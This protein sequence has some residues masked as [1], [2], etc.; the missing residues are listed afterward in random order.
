MKILILSCD[1]GQGHN[2]AARAVEEAA[3]RRSIPC[4]LANPLSFG[5]KNRAGS[6]QTSTTISSG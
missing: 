1:T 2:S 5:G 6:R 4:C 3:G